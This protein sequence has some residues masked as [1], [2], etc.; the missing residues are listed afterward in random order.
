MKEIEDKVIKLPQWQ[1]MPGTALR[2]GYRVLSGELGREHEIYGPDGEGDQ[3]VALADIYRIPPDLTD[4]ATRGLLRH[5]ATVAHGAFDIHIQTGIAPRMEGAS[6]RWRTVDSQGRLLRTG[7][8]VVPLDGDAMVYGL[9]AALEA[10]PPPAMTITAT[11]ITK[12][13]VRYRRDDE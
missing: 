8:F 4:P 12:V 9:V 1:H 2:Y 5:L 11:G 3:D 10:A 7:G 13:C 6:G